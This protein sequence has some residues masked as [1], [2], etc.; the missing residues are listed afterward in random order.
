MG[1]D[2]ATFWRAVWYAC[3]TPSIPEIRIT[4]KS[5][6][7]GGGGDMTIFE[8]FGNDLNKLAIFAGT[9]QKYS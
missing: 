1:P 7:W 6:V 5:C 2:S 9:T 4:I 8:Y 3:I